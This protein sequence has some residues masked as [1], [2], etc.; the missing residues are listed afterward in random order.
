MQA[1]FIRNLLVFCMSVAA[2]HAANAQNAARIYIE[3]NGWSIGTNAGLSD[4]FGDIG[5]QSAVDHYTNSNYI[6]RVAFMG[7]MFGRYT[8]HP[9]L[10]LKLSLN[11]GSLYASDKW[12]YDLAIVAKTQG[13]DGY[14]RYA[15]GQNAR[16]FIFEGS[17]VLEITPLRI[18]P[19]SKLAHRRGQPYVGVGFGYFHYTPYSTVG[20]GTRWVKTYDLSLEGQ[21][22]AGSTFP[23][24]YSLWSM[25]VPLA[26]GYRWDLGEHL[27]VGIEYKYRM[28]FTDYLDGVSG[29]YISKKD[30]EKNL[31]P[32]NAKTAYEIAD[33]SYFYGLSLPDAAGNLR[34]N[35]SNNDAYTTLMITFYYKILSRTREWW[36]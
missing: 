30:F 32:A 14:Q 21:G 18:N 4:M 11:Y 19:E 8:I 12:N 29:K 6:K 33:K 3:P 13:D 20:K 28:T 22:F 27:N 24:K 10:A 16:D 2:G 35:A 36:H 25:A 31:S 26:I 15:R 7:G 23:G 34:G 9:A 5:T 17:S 1:R